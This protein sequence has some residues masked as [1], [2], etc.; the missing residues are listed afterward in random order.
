M[1]M[2]ASKCPMC[3]SPCMIKII[4]TSDKRWCEVDVCRMCGTMYPRGKLVTKPPSEA[5][6]KR[7]SRAKKP[8]KAPKKAGTRKKAPKKRPK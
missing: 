2:V 4:A 5:L 1:T 6:K 8:G 3:E 7:A